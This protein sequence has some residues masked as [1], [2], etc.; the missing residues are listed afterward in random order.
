MNKVSATDVTFITLAMAD[1]G[2]AAD[3]LIKH[4]YYVAGGLLVLGIVLN[5]LYHKYGTV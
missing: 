3:F 5:Y 2:A 4:D 1:F